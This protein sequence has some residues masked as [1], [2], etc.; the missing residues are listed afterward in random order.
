MTSLRVISAGGHSSLLFAVSEYLI[1]GTLFDFDGLS[2][3]QT[4]SNVFLNFR[5]AA[6]GQKEIEFAKQILRIWI[7]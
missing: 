1:I 4:G 3:P 7:L 2:S 6:A 5:P